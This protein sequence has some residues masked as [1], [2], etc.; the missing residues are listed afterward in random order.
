[1]LDAPGTALYPWD[2][3]STYI[4][5]P[6]FATVHADERLGTYV[7]DPIIVVGDDITTDHISPAGAVPPRSEAAAYLIARGENPLD[8]NVFSARRGNW[9]AMVRGL[10]T[11]KTVRNLLADGL[12]PGQTIHA[13][14]GEVV[15]LWDAA[16]RYHN[17]GRSVVIVAGDRYGMGSS[18]DWAAKGASLL[19][20]R[21]VLATSFERIHRS[22]LVNMGVLP[23]RLPDAHHPSKLQLKPGDKIEIEAEPADVVPH[24]DIP[25]TIH[26]SGGRREMIS[27]RAVVET[28]LEARVLRSGGMIPLILQ[29]KLRSGCVQPGYAETS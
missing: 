25:I 12:P 4:R 9:E 26:R 16:Q 5:R 22:N 18:R 23:L 6:P 2:P 14:S 3:A 7:A 19:G 28:S 21:A 15:S 27:A 20:A 29:S 11:N 8:L 1:M 13:P 10:F 24:A 17:E